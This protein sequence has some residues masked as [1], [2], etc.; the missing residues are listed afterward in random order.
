MIH[1]PPR[2]VERRQLSGGATTFRHAH[3]TM[4]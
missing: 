2:F 3:Q 4:A 1:L